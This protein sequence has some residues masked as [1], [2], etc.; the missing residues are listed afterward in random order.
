[1]INRAIEQ[2]GRL[3]V[4]VNNA[5]FGVVGTVVDTSEEDWNRQ[6]AVN[7]NGVF[8][9]CKYAIPRMIAQ[10][11]GVIVNT[12][13]RAAFRGP[14]DRAGYAASKG[15]VVSL[16]QAIAADH[17]RDGIRINCVAPGTVDTPWFD[18][19]LADVEDKEAWHKERTRQQPMGRY[20]SAQEIANGVLFLASDDASY[21][22]GTSLVI[23]GGRG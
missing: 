17:T 15:A 9:G 21:I 6:M 1:M 3:D 2:R 14:R 11:G 12:A 16:T 8:F 5:G 7:L 20:A 18:A 4:L 19:I 22:T 13:S 10:G 23:D